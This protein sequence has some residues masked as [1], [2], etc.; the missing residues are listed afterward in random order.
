[1]RKFVIICLCVAFVDGLIS[2]PS[3]LYAGENSTCVGMMCGDSRT[4]WT[5]KQRSAVEGPWGLWWAM[6]EVERKEMFPNFYRGGGWLGE[7][8][9]GPAAGL[10]FGPW[11]QRNF[12]APMEQTPPNIDIFPSIPGKVYVIAPF[13]GTIGKCGRSIGR[14]LPKLPRKEI[15]S[16][17]DPKN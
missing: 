9:L 12:W 1:M 5:D 17:V 4:Y 3:F 16:I 11:M 8:V 2:Q 6:G 15:S 10:T 14:I 7:N 13:A